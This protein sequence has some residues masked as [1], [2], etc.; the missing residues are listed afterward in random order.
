VL[1]VVA[2]FYDPEKFYTLSNHVHRY[3]GFHTTF[4]R[5]QGIGRVSFSSDIRIVFHCTDVL[6]GPSDLLISWC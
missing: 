2:F 5:H 6:C 3:D 1:L 4:L